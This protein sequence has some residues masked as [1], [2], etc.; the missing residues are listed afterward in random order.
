M[1]GQ[2]TLQPVPMHRQSG[3]TRRGGR[4][5]R[6]QSVSQGA[7]LGV[8]SA[9][10]AAA[11]ITTRDGI[12]GEWKPPTTNPTQ[13]AFGSPANMALWDP[14][15]RAA[16][17]DFEL[18]S[19]LGFSADDAHE[20]ASVCHL[21]TAPGALKYEPL[22]QFVRPD[23]DTFKLQLEYL[24]SYADL[25]PDRATE[26]LEQLT[27]PVPFL[28]AI[29]FL[30]PDNKHW[31]LELLGAVFRLATH[32]EH[33][34]KHALACRRPIELSPQVQPIIQTPGHGSLPSGHAT[35]SFAAALVLRQLMKAS[36]TAPY[37]DNSYAVQL[38][39]LAARIAINRTVAGVH[40]PIDSVAGA[41][42]GL[43]LGDYFLAR[44]TADNQK[45]RA[46]KFDGKATGID[47]RDFLWSDIYDV[48][49][50]VKFGNPHH[51]SVEGGAAV[52]LTQDTPSEP[53]RYLWCKAL[54]EWQVPT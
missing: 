3:P 10:L 34:V 5:V 17:I 42:L 54:A 4:M 24:T 7:V 6:T 23:E 33:R 40:F 25:R 2:L 51:P 19:R 48:D 41:L 38:M 50:G 21:R 16:V 39:R 13:H 28:G 29:G 15:Y 47:D 1:N 30:R 9:G 44:A 26:I 49:S 53:L 46:A 22:A 36:G 8:D 45:Y 35:E 18:T 32:V 27:V 12:V 31:T 14:T 11:L 37:V 20:T 52:D 43:T